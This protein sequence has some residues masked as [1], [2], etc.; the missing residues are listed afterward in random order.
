[1]HT[2]YAHAD[3]PNMVVIKYQEEWFLVLNIPG[4]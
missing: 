3:L 1:M 2:M 4:G